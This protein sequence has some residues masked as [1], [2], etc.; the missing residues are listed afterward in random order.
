MA[1]QRAKDEAAG[2]A[3]LRN[4]GIIAHIDAGKTTLTE[5]ILFYAGKIH[6][7][8]EVHEGTAT[9]DYLP[10]EQ[11]RGI[12][13][14]SACATVFLADHQINVIDTPGHVDFTIEVERSLRV[15]DGAVGVFCAV[16]GVE[17]QSET[18]WRQSERYRVPKL[19]FVNKMDRPGA[20]FPA[21]L[22]SMRDRLSAEPLALQ[23]PLGAGSDFSGAVD[24]VSMEALDF[25][26][27]AVSRRSLTDAE[28]AL[29]A[30]WRD[31]LLESLA[32]RDDGLM[33]AYLGGRDITAD[34]IKAA[35]RKAA[36][37]RSLTPVLVGSALRNMGVTPVMDAI[38]DYLP[39]PADIGPVHGIHAHT[40]A[41]MELP[42]SPKAPFCA[43]V[44]KVV[45]EAGR[46]LVLA[47]IYSGILAEGVE[48]QNVTQGKKERIGRIFHLYAGE[49]EP[50]PQAG[51]GE[52]V[53]I[54]GMKLPRTGDTLADVA[55][56]ILLEAISQYKP[57]LSLAIEPRNTEEL[58]KLK[59]AVARLV[60]E[61]PTLAGAYDE[62]AGQLIL[63]GMGELHLDVTLER[64]RREYGLS[65][66]AGKPQVVCQE[67][68]TRK[69]SA[70]AEF[71]RELG[72][73]P[74]YGKVV[75]TVAPTAR[76]SG[77][78]IGLSA[79]DPKI[80]P[81]AWLAAVH[82]GLE[83]ALHSGVLQGAPVQDVSVTV[84]ELGRTDH[85]SAVGYRMAA[86][87][88]LKNAL[89]V[90]NSAL[91]QPIMFL[92]ISVPDD[93]VGDVIGLLGAKGAKIENLFDRG[94][95]KVIQGLT[96]L[97]RLF[98]FSTDLRSATQ[99]R[100]GLVMQF[101]RFDLLD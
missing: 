37:E 95:Q 47:R 31:T 24:L 50:L 36:I 8:G 86:A 26:N 7:M 20:D 29:A 45:M 93:F 74:H 14:T 5:R 99:G 68:V 39:S 76:G 34:Q 61:D 40:H 100:A 21:V 9:M 33:E 38:V 91:L 35:V 64:M 101:A 90:A 75:V 3:R 67:T 53:G 55:H 17:P 56:P 89:S 62:D 27:D 71:D 58:E 18:V 22:R 60:L 32:E 79:F 84:T 98:G 46:K 28:A 19:A 57:V 30:P 72:G 96:P 6:R 80:W 42:A 2:I 12:T 81:K 87:Q 82:E 78:E 85:S 88:A 51:P 69:A 25:T 10:E 92:E 65:P 77:R 94:G 63:E 59:D 4:I 52:I 73:E 43:L 23:M 16:A 15:L 1:A 11:E 48:A 70:A 41:P 13:I 97:G 54:S 44:F 49:K 83:D 66:R